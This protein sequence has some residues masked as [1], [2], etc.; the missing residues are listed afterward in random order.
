VTMDSLKFEFRLAEFDLG[1][2][3]IGPDLLKG[4][5]ALLREA[6]ETYLADYFKR[7]GGQASIA[8]RDDVV[9]V[10]WTPYSTEDFGRLKGYALSLLKD[11]AFAQAQ[12]IIEALLRRDPNDSHLLLDYGMLLSDAGRVADAAQ[13]LSGATER[14]P[15]DAQAWNALGVARGRQNRLEEATAALE[16]AYALA[17]EDGACPQELRVAGRQAFDDRGAPAAGQGGGVAARRPDRLVQLRALPP[18]PG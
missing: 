18:A 3:S 5:A 4:N 16:R 10:T 7:V 14:N 12:P 2:L 6:V 8:T 17:P 15:N 11:G 9:T 1:L 13:I